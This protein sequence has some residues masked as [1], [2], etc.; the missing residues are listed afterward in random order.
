MEALPKGVIGACHRRWTGITQ[1]GGDERF[2]L[3]NTDPLK[4]Y[5]PLDKKAPTLATVEDAWS[6]AA[7]LVSETYPRENSNR[8]FVCLEKKQFAWS[9]HS[10]QGKP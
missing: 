3:A 2:R 6:F 4:P 7:L 9:I 10:S 8:D 5:I 1:D